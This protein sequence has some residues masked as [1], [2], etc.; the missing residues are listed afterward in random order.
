MME[1]HLEPI[2]ATDPKR[3]ALFR[4]RNQMQAFTGLF[5]QQRGTPDCAAH[6]G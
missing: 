1:E 3:F 6:G 4:G 5:A 2:R